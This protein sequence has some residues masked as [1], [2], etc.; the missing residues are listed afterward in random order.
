[1][2]T[3]FFLLLMLTSFIAVCQ[4]NIVK[5]D[6]SEIRAKIVKIELE[7]I[8]Y[9]QFSN[10]EGATDSISKSEI[11][12][13][14]YE[15]GTRDVFNENKS[16]VLIDEESSDD[17]LIIKSYIFLHGGLR[18]GIF[19]A[20]LRPSSFINNNTS[21]IYDKLALG[22]GGDIEVG[23]VIYLVPR[24]IPK[25]LGVGINITLANVGLV[26]IEGH[27]SNLSPYTASIGPQLSFQASKSVLLDVF[28]KPGTSLIHM[29]NMFLPVFQLE[30]GVNFRYKK[31]MIG[32]SGA[33]MPTRYGH[34][35]E[36]SANQNY[37]NVPYNYSHI[38]LKVG[39]TIQKK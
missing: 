32:L 11:F 26:L 36:P 35:N 9:K 4:D 34:Y 3:L 16:W 7:V 31:L 23:G 18:V 5:I 17:S 38:R 30:L 28:F 2:K 27:S 33:F 12:M 1:M 39:T 29:A 8:K 6:G 19:P 10:L 14:Q 15:D 37:Y 20:D 25:K 13:I 24:K 21:I 22:V